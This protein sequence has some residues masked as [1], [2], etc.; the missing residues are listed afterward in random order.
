MD[1]VLESAVRALCHQ[2]PLSLYI[3]KPQISHETNY[4]QVICGDSGRFLF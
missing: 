1:V 4:Q 3:L 2:Q